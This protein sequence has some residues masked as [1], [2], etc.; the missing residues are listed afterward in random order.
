MTARV[1]IAEDDPDIGG[2]VRDTLAERLGVAAEIVANGALVIAAVQRLRPAL[3]LLDVELPGLNGIDV[4]EMLGWEPGSPTRILF[5]TG[6][7]DLAGRAFAGAEVMTKPF[8]LD[9][10]V[11]RVAE[12]IGAEAPA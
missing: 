6:R 9:V 4:F 10:L 8:D 1:L 11:A 7:P 3:L 5:V 2:M 12:L